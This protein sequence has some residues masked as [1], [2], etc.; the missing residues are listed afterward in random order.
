MRRCLVRNPVT[1]GVAMH[2]RIA[3]LLAVI[4]IAPLTPVLAQLDWHPAY[5]SSAVPP[6]ARFQIVQSELG[7]RFTFRL[8][9]WTGT[10]SLMT[11]RDDSS[12]AWEQMR[13]LVNPSPD[14]QLPGRPNYLLFLSGLGNRYTFL[15]NLNTGATWQIV[16]NPNGELL[17]EP[18]SK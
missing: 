1:R 7:A 6:G 3:M 8:D 10:V 16:E 18:L 5:T 13:R 15:I 12:L 9:S 14:T 2:P 17:W 11:M 4:S